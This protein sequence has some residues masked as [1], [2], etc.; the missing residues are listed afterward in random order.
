MYT[1][2]CFLRNCIQERFTRKHHQLYVTFIELKEY[3]C[4]FT[5]D[6]PQIRNVSQIFRNTFL[7][8][9]FGFTNDNCKILCTQ[10]ENSFTKHQNGFYHTKCQTCNIS[11]IAQKSLW[12][13]HRY[14]QHSRYI[15]TNN[16]Q[17]IYSKHILDSAHYYGPT[18]TAMTLIKSEQTGRYLY[19]VEIYFNRILPINNMIINARKRF[20]AALCNCQK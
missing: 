2:Y 20:K 15:T 4:D 3:M 17:S 9:T 10:T 13:E 16:P 8:I 19:I 1:R 14:R 11:H 6:V 12:L 7:K 18:D 5:Y